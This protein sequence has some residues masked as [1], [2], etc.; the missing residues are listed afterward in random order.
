MYKRCFKKNDSGL[1]ESYKKF[2]NKLTTIKRITNKITIQLWLIWTKKT[3]QNNGNLLTKFCNEIIKENCPQINYVLKIIK[4]WQS[5]NCYW[6]KQLQNF[7]NVGPKIAANIPSTSLQTDP[8]TAVS[9]W[10]NSFSVIHARNVK[11]FKK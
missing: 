8:S 7:T 4:F 11:Y 5:R 2:S 10:D 1:I 6:I 3:Y 9:S